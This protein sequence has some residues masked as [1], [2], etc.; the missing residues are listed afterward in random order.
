[1]YIYYLLIVAGTW[2]RRRETWLLARFLFQD[3]PEAFLRS[4][5]KH[6]AHHCHQHRHHHRHHQQKNTVTT[7]IIIIIDIIIII[8]TGIITTIE[9]TL[10]VL[11]FGSRGIK[12]TGT[13]IMSAGEPAR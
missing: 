8:A 10:A 5:A 7:I 3:Q 9:S 2:L 13:G 11:L 6:V 4:T 1:M 12:S